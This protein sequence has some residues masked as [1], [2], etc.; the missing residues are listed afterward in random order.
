[1]RNQKRIIAA[2]LSAVMIVGAASCG[3]GRGQGNAT[4]GNTTTEGSKPVTGEDLIDPDE[5]VDYNEMANIDKIDTANEEGAGTLYESGKMAGEVKAFC[6]YNIEDSAKD[7]SEIFATR[8]GGVLKTEICSSSLEYFSELGKLITSGLSPDLVRYDWAA[9]PDSISKGIYTPLDEWLNIDSPLWSDVRDA[10]E[11]YEFKGKHYYFP[12]RVMP[13]FVMLYNTASIEKANLE[14]PMDLYFRNEWTWDKFE[15]MLYTWDSISDDYIPYTGGSWS[16]MMFINTTGSKIIDITDNDII[17]NLKTE[18]VMRTMNWL[19]KLNREG[20][21]GTGYVHPQDAFADGNLLFLSM[22]CDWGFESAQKCLFAKKL[23]G[24][25]RFVPF[26]RD[27]QAD[28][29]YI[30]ADTFGYMVP[31]G[32]QNVQGAVQWILSG[33]INYTDPEVIE[34]KRQES[35]STDPVYYS[36]CPNKDCGFKCEGTEHED[37]PTCPQCGTERKTKFKVTFTEDQYQIY[38][39]LTDPEKFGLVFDCAVGFK[40]DV[41]HLFVETDDTILDSPLFGKD[42]LVTYT[43]QLEEKYN[44]FETYLDEYRAILKQ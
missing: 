12:E 25:I 31:S 27:P 37:S 28:K 26:P 19:E 36:K 39:D 4:G 18:N 29:Y 5:K 6:Y 9:Y 1:M 13:N 10:I 14:D 40:D 21:T 32:A 41:K 11:S 24:E 43:S 2:L 34:A 22:G 42:E 44:V 17:N 15:D 20:L 16:S 7:I 30:P 33:R 8:F 38:N 3:G 35:L 23:E